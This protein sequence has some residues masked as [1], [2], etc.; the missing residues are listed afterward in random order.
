MRG[1]FK[2]VGLSLAGIVALIIGLAIL[3]SFTKPNSGGGVPPK[4]EWASSRCGMA[5]LYAL[6]DAIKGL[7]AYETEVVIARL[8]GEGIYVECGGLGGCVYTMRNFQDSRCLP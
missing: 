3:A 5:G 4:V 8:A 7:T 2:F 6:D 1:F